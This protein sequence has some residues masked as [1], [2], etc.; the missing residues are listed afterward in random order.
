MA[1]VQNRISQ[2]TS[3]NNDLEFDVF[4]A[5]LNEA[6][7]KHTPIK[8]WYVRANQASFIIFFVYH[9]N[10]LVITW[11]DHTLQFIYRVKFANLFLALNNN[12]L[13]LK[14]IS[15]KLYYMPE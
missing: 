3:E 5:V 12:M 11:S 9:S 6:I 10:F 14:G 2:M 8:Q 1:N 15:D 13:D 4:K 7:Q